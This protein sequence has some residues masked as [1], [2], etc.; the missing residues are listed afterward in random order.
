MCQSRELQTQSPDL[1]AFQAIKCPLIL[2]DLW[3]S[4][5]NPE[6]SAVHQILWGL[7]DAVIQ[8]SIM[9]CSKTMKVDKGKGP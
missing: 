6:G 9:A 2:K 5:K 1:N 7:F 8:V 3:I 4:D